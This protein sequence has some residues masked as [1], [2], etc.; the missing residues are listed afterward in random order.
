MQVKARSQKSTSGVIPQTP[1]T[2][3]FFSFETG[4]LTKCAGLASAPVIRLSPGPQSWDHK[5]VSLHLLFCTGSRDK[6]WVLRLVWPALY[7]RTKL[8]P[9][10]SAHASF[11]SWCLQPLKSPCLYHELSCVPCFH[12]D[13]GL[14]GRLKERH[15]ALDPILPKLCS[16]QPPLG[17]E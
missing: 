13:W 5:S 2:S 4:S 3:L 17:Q 10:P 9:Q 16:L 7:Q 1:S 8:S 14:Q 11:I 15:I 6:T 12:V